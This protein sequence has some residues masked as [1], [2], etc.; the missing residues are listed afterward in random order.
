[1]ATNADHAQN[2]AA[3][4]TAVNQPQPLTVDD[5]DTMAA[6]EDEADYLAVARVTGVIHTGPSVDDATD[7]VAVLYL[8]ENGAAV[9]R[10]APAR[11]GLDALPRAINPDDDAV[12]PAGPNARR[13]TRLRQRH[14]D[15]EDTA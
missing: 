1:M 5:L 14:E 15:L 6:P 10:W 11:D 8:D 7:G 4:F 9:E 13:L 2:D 3:S 12:E